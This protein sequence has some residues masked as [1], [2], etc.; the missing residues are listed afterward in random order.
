LS[1]ALEPVR[2][3]ELVNGTAIAGYRDGEVIIS[4]PEP[5][6]ADRIAGEYGE[7]IA[8][9][10]SEAMRRPV[11]I[12]VLVTQPSDGARSET[13]AP[14]RSGNG[15]KRSR[16][17]L[18]DMPDADPEIP[19]FIVAECGL[20]SAQVWAAVIDEVAAAGEVSTANVDAWL[21][22]TRLIGR[23][24]DGGL[25]VGAVHGLAQRRIASRFATSLQSAA[26]AILGTEVPMEIVVSRDWL[27]A[28]NNPAPDAT[29]EAVGAA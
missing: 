21:R 13:P 14:T 20:P 1:G 27:L 12:A 3:A 29:V 22:S 11:R 7:L 23:G 16:A 19:S 5:A 4:V 17:A 8:R 15:T 18:L 26:A 25:I 2:L 6:Q 28:G 24:A 9:K 10:V